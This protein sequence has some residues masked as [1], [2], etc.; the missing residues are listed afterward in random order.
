MMQIHIAQSR[1]D[2]RARVPDLEVWVSL[3]WLAGWF[4]DISSGRVEGPQGACQKLPNW[5]SWASPEKGTVASV[6]ILAQAQVHRLTIP[7][8]YCSCLCT[9]VS[10]CES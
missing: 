6:T 4:A 2:F 7:E 3:G 8:S 1:C 5:S 9:P 10:E